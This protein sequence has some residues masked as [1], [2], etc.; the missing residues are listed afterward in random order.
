[1]VRESGYGPACFARPSV[2]ADEICLG[3]CRRS[4]CHSRPV[5]IPFRLPAGPCLC[6]QRRRALCRS[7][8]E[9]DRELGRKQST[10][11]GAALDLWTGILAADSGVVLRSLRLSPF[12]DYDTATGRAAAV[13]DRRA[14]LAHHANRGLRTIAAQQPS[15]QRSGWSMDGWNSLPCTDG[16]RRLAVTA[17]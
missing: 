16:P 2:D 4:Q 6:N 3:R 17:R 1:M 8:L 13:D 12:A 14:C 11:V 9:C 15:I 10:D 5:Q 7:L